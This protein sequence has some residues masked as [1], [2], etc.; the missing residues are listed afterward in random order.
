VPFAHEAETFAHQPA[1]SSGPTLLT[2]SLVP[3]VDGDYSFG[4][5]GLG[6]RIASL[7]GGSL[8]GELIWTDGLF[9]LLRESVTNGWWEIDLA[10][11]PAQDTKWGTNYNCPHVAPAIVWQMEGLFEIVAHVEITGGHYDANVGVFAGAPNA[12]DNNSSPLIVTSWG[13]WGPA[14]VHAKRQVNAAADSVSSGNQ[15]GTERWLRLARAVGS[16]GHSVAEYAQ[17]ALVGDSWAKMDGTA[18]K[19]TKQWDNLPHRCYGGLC[20]GG[21]ALDAVTTFKI[22]QID[23]SYY[24]WSP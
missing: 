2:K 24:A 3:Q 1:P 17:K 6:G 22:R 20:F 5:D 8:D 7:T 23:L 18:G 9:A 14:R 16:A 21:N 15:T 19:E 13:Q 4:D 11:L 12:D 10:A